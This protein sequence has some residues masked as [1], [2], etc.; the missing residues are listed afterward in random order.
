[1]SGERA[2]LW[3]KD[4]FYE[5]NKETLETVIPFGSSTQE[6]DVLIVKD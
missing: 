1:V 3:L 5:V 4:K 2:G 6:H